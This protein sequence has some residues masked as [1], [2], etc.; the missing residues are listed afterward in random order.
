MYVWLPAPTPK[1]APSPTRVDEFLN[2]AENVA[3]AIVAIPSSRAPHRGAR[4]AERD[5]P[6]DDRL[7]EAVA[8]GLRVREVL[9]E[10]RARLVGLVPVPGSVVA[11]AVRIGVRFEAAGVAIEDIEAD[12][13]ALGRAD[14]RQELHHA[15]RRPAP[16]RRVEPDDDL[17]RN[18]AGEL[19]DAMTEADEI[20]GLVVAA[21]H[22][23]VNQHAHARRDCRRIAAVES[24]RNPAPRARSRVCR[25]PRGV[26][27]TQ[28]HLLPP[29]SHVGRIG[30][31][32]LVRLPVR[33]HPVHVEHRDRA[34]GVGGIGEN[35]HERSAGVPLG[36][37]ALTRETDEI[38][39]VNV[40][41]HAE[42][43]RAV[44]VVIVVEIVAHADH[45]VRRAT[46]LA[47]EVGCRALAGARAARTAGARTARTAGA[48]TARTAGARTARAARHAGSTVCAAAARCA[49][50][51]R[52]ALAAARSGRS[53]I[54]GSAL[55]R[56][57]TATLPRAAGAAR[58]VVAGASVVLV[59][60]A[61]GP[62]R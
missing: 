8:D 35:V 55:A 39:V 11:L 42:R 28:L 49:G 33:G 46:E 22:V 5:L 1:A 56:A 59:A 18:G 7:S 13:I 9:V 34:V 50:A 43:V 32:G 44:P 38:R 20:F 45:E 19:D 53:S 21:L 10:I 58:T 3:D 12:V 51:G 61:A 48:R 15:R 47:C 41:R 27:K 29:G 62:G 14:G 23:V 37:A 30:Q 26:W 16:T 31:H 17:R 4:H 2:V 6:P 54:T 24:P 60:T 36:P 25:T 57:G 40:H 52:A